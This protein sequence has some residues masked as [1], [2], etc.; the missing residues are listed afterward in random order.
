[1]PSH[2][3]RIAAIVLAPVLSI[4]ASANAQELVVTPIHDYSY[5]GV[6]GEPVVVIADLA[7]SLPQPPLTYIAPDNETNFTFLKPHA[8]ALFSAN[9]ALASHAANMN[10]GGGAVDIID[11]VQDQRLGSF[12]MA[13][14]END[15]Y[16]TY[17]IN[18]ARTH[19]L[20]FSGLSNSLLFVVP[21]P[22]SES[23]IAS[24]VLMPG[25]GGTAQTHA[26]VFDN[27]TGRAYVGHR[28]GISALDPPYAS[29]AFTI[30]LPGAGGSTVEGRAIAL[31]PDNAALAST[32]YE[33]GKVQM[34]HAPFSA[35]STPTTLTVPNALALDGLEFTPDGTKLLVVDAHVPATQAPTAPWMTFSNINANASGLAAAGPAATMGSRN[36]APDTASIPQVFAISAPFDTNAPIEILAAGPSE[37]EGF[38]DIDISADGQFAALSGGTQ[39]AGAPLVVLRAPFTTAGVT[40]YPIYIPPL[41]G[42]YD[43]LGGRG[44]G[45]ARFWSAPIAP[46]PQ[47]TTDTTVSAT[48]GD[49]GTSPLV[50][51]ALLSHASAQSVTVQ[52]ATADESLTAPL[53]YLATSGTLT[54]APGETVKTLSVP[55][56]GNTNHD[57]DGFFE[58]DFSNPIHASLL[59]IGAHVQCEV[60][61]NDS[62]FII[63]TPSPLPDG[64]VGAPY[65]LA[66][67]T[68]GSPGG[69]ITWT[70]TPPS[71]LSLDPVTGVLGGTPTSAG[72][73]FFNVLANAGAT[74]TGRGYQLTIHGDRIF[75]NGFETGP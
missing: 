73:Y 42:S 60:F 52:Y 50:L 37:A 46:I 72:R 30:P 39:T 4:S 3:S 75:A 15:G 74:G 48:E 49:S 70:A 21:A 26:I 22:F 65:A 61:D 11:T 54:F 35:A 59:G 19:M 44:A 71:S 51:H 2:L 69:A 28:A 38:E 53:R 29:I 40:A 17:A 5:S 63:T 41:N 64:F 47:I 31:S 67:A 6:K 12:A 55:I 34:L 27:V 1:M 8:L 32:L 56:V 7:S 24:T 13:G 10:G 20:V 43:S 16:G 57:G 33:D 68:A 18:P 14:Y 36:T 25:R 62:R 45:T 23:S 66:F 9:L 58:V